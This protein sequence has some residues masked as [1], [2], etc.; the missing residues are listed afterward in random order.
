MRKLTCDNNVMVSE[1]DPF[2][3]GTLAPPS[4]PD[5]VSLYTQH[6]LTQCKHQ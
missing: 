1:L 4:V 5:I 3:G 6:D 2:P